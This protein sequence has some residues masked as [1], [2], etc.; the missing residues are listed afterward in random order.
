M[1]GRRYAVLANRYTAGARNFLGNLGGRQYAAVAWLR[2]LA[3]LQLHHLDLIERS[4][5][6]KPLRRKG[7]IGIAGAKISG[8]DFP[9][10]VAPMFAVIGGIT[11]LP[12]IMCEVAGLGA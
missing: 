12:G 6:R 10:D 4:G 2:A 8:A 11:A 5:L 3:D 9:D 7:T 1:A